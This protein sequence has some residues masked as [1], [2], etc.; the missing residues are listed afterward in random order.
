MC[1][2]VGAYQ[3]SGN[4]SV[5][6]DYLIKMRDSMKHRGPD[7]CGIWIS[8]NKNIGLAHRRLSILDLSSNA[9]QPMCNDDK[10]IQLVFN[11]EIYNHK[12]LR[13]ELTNEH[14]IKWNTSHSDT[15]VII[16]SYEVWGIDCLKRFRGMFA[17]ALWD[18]RERKLW[19]VRDRVGIKPLYWSQHHGRIIFASEIKALLCDPDLQRK[20]NSTAMAD[21][22]AFICT[23]APNTMFE[24]IQKLEPGTWLCIDDTG[25]IKEHRWYDVLD[26][27]DPSN[28][29]KGDELYEQ[30]FD[31]LNDSINIHKE[32]DVPVGIF[33]S[34]GVDS[35][36]N[37]KLFSSGSNYPLKTFTIGYDAEYD[38]YTNELP[39]ARQMADEIGAIHHEK[40]LSEK[41]LL[42]FLP[43]MI[44][45]QDEPIADPVCMPVYFVSKLARA[46]NIKVCQVGE[47]ADELFWGYD[48]WKQWQKLQHWTSK[49]WTQSFSKFGTNFMEHFGKSNNRLYDSLL[50]AA[51]KKPAFWTS[52]Q[53]PTRYELN[54]LLGQD[55]KREIGKIDG[56]DRIEPLWKRFKDKAWEQSALSWMSFVELSLRIPE[57]L[58]M[59]VDKMSMGASLEA[60]VPFLDHKFVELAMSIPQSRKMYNNESKHVL[61]QALRGHIPNNIINRKKTGFGVPV[62]E[63]L[64]NS[65]GKKI[66][67]DIKVFCKET[68]IFNWNGISSLLESKSRVRIWYVYNF[69]LWH[70]YY[71][72][73]VKI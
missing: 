64:N 26:H 43:D 15:E 38:T 58:L 17:I 8:D 63:W 66:E 1:G 53:G 10:T 25:Q 44:R 57:L 4:F 22:F 36:A 9:S 6:P 33:L 50:R 42:E 27:T 14:N 5:T 31:S 28:V 46:N 40:L 32:S 54:L 49:P 48:S 37:A 13:D 55:I 65:L 51:Q 41:N 12:E 29:R 11:G 18:S 73:G 3:Y 16:K 71:I 52:A 56:W 39:F 61:K 34:G 2:L 72:Q 45:L 20:C 70:K 68:G 21:Y 30:V 7:G 35:S 62:Y 23:P 24:G 47:G 69:V 59:R 19:L 60:R 67:E